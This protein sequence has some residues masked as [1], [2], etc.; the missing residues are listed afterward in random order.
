MQIK[1]QLFIP[2]FAVLF[3]FSITHAAVH[4]EIQWKKIT[5]EHFEVIFDAAQAELGALYASRLEESYRRL[6][7]FF[8]EA[9]QKTIVALQDRT[10]T[11]N[12]SATA[13]PYPLIVVYPVL[14]NTA[15]T[16]SEYGDWALDLATHEYTH[17]L[18]FHQHSEP[19]TTLRS[20]FG[21]IVTPNI[22]LPR[23]YLE[24]VA[25]YTETRL[26]QHG[27][28]RSPFQDAMIRAWVE[29]GRWNDFDLAEINE[30]T[31]P[32]W[33]TGARPY[34]FGS[35][36]WAHLIKEHGDKTIANL[37]TR[38]GGRV[39]YFL[40]APFLDETSMSYEAF[41]DRLKF[42]IE[43]MA[44]KQL[45]D[46]RNLPFT[47]SQ[48]LELKGITQTNPAISPDGSKL[49][50][51]SRND[52]GKKSLVILS[53]EDA[54]QPFSKESK[55]IQ[56]EDA[57][58]I[59]MTVRAGDAPAAGAI[60]QVSWFADSKR[61][62][63]D[64]VDSINRFQSFADLYLVDIETQKTIRLSRG[65]RARDA[66]PSPDQN[67]L[68]FVKIEGGKTHLAVMELAGKS[69]KILHSPALQTRIANPTWLDDQT[70]AFTER[71]AFG[72]ESLRTLDISS[73]EMK[74][75]STGFRVTTQ[76]KLTT[77]GM[78]VLS[79]HSGVLNAY[80]L[81]ANLTN[82]R[83]ITHVNS[84]V[85]GADLD[86]ATGD[87]YFSLI[88][89]EGVRLH[90]LPAANFVETENLPTLKPLYNEIVSGDTT[91]A[92]N[93]DA[94]AIEEYSPISYLMPRY[95]LPLLAYDQRGIYA[96]VST[97]SADPLQKH[98]YS[99]TAGWDSYLKKGN[100]NLAYINNNYE[101][102]LTFI[103][104][105]TNSYLVEKSIAT[106]E[107]LAAIEAL[108]PMM[109]WNQ[110]TSTSFGWTYRQK[111][112]QG[113][114]VQRV[115]PSLGIKYG[116][117]SQGVAQIS[118]ETGL[119][120]SLLYTNYLADMSDLSY[121]QVF[122][123]FQYYF[124][125]GL[126]AHHVLYFSTI[127]VATDKSLSDLNTL[128][129]GVSSVGSNITNE[130]LAIPVRGYL[131]GQFT[132][133]KIHQATMEYRFPL[134]GVYQGRGILPLFVK[135][136]HAAVLGDAISL[137][138]FAYSQKSRAFKPEDLS[139]VYASTGVELNVDTTLGYAFPLTFTVAYYQPLSSLLGNSGSMF[140]GLKM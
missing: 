51:V 111:T 92:P 109:D 68:A 29:E 81:D 16:L 121:Q 55:S 137:K 118:P 69:V 124:N 138:G 108:W 85:L 65:L 37:H 102:Q 86:P 31:I 25:V 99:V 26:G 40:D 84:G 53:R 56:F 89:A 127:A 123:K 104:A 5:T 96:Q 36:Y 94:Y 66:S 77:K 70:I 87:L 126:P 48:N 22:L 39:P 9:P 78:L 113:S 132:G 13:F 11:T 44:R 12:G 38:Y 62:V 47:Q 27:R 59:D 67:Q 98:A 18:S 90:R 107:K 76:A 45:Q 20:I 129:Y 15:D 17:I 134:V 6:A 21:S 136:F 112:I 133:T 122:G 30:T 103:S 64:K 33:P 3:S 91:I 72:A 82:P 130:S 42:E 97:S 74:E 95:W 7:P 34:I 83:P 41:Y 73:G 49:L 116:T 75:A 117:V 1:I 24:G 135:R 120:A 100:W 79:P 14:P 57:D 52:N 61:I 46:L 125:K 60:G 58:Q 93:P 106:E 35:L 131:T 105:N 32:T 10:D 139:R 50:Y 54:T 88:T 119:Q 2:I 128:F 101:P 8:P 140:F 28:L 110:D 19:V 63:Y 4:P 115:G 71:N 80:R 23:W 114:G 43:T